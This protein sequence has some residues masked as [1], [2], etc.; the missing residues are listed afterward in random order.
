METSHP[1]P[2]CAPLAAAYLTPRHR[3]RRGRNRAAWAMAETRMAARAEEV[4]DGGC[5]AQN[6]Y[7]NMLI[8]LLTLDSRSSAPV[9]FPTDLP[10]LFSAAMLARSDC[11][12]RVF[13]AYVKGN[14][15]RCT[16][17]SALL[18][19]TDAAAIVHSDV[20]DNPAVSRSARSLDLSQFPGSISR[21]SF[22]L[23]L[24][25]L[26]CNPMIKCPYRY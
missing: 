12:R 11:F 23:L 24:I 4:I 20:A 25:Y 9:C 22:R 8:S 26:T 21:F 16:K 3:P 1:F 19:F 7:E 17:N 10:F 15:Q 5:P 6:T 13:L 2:R 18:T 14:Q